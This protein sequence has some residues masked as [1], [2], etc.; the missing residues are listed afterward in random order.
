MGSSSV[1]SSDFDMLQSRTQSIERSFQEIKNRTT[2]AQWKIVFENLSLLQCNI[3]RHRVDNDVE[4]ISQAN[5]ETLASQDTSSNLKRDQN[6]ARVY[7]MLL[8]RK[9]VHNPENSFMMDEVT[10]LHPFPVQ[11]IHLLLWI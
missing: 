3:A 5:A 7:D 4:T 1:M 6:A 10:L 9:K 11:G 2:P 8:P